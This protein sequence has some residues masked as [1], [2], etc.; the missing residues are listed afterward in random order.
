MQVEDHAAWER[1]FPVKY[2]LVHQGEE[3]QEE[4]WGRCAG[5]E[6]MF[7]DKV[8]PPREVLTLRGCAPEGLLRD[9]LM[10]SGESSALLGEVC[11]EVWDEEQP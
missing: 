10:P 3:D 8:P 1:G 5:A 6:G 11:V 2:L 9:A 4:F 7:V